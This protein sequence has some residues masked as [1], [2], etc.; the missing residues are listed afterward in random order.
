VHALNQLLAAVTAG[1]I[2]VASALLAAEPELLGR[3]DELGRTPLHVAAAEAQLTAACMLLDRGASVEPLA[4]GGLSPLA[5]VMGSALSEDDKTLLLELL[6]RKGALYDIPTAVISNDLEALGS[7]LAAHP[8]AVRPGGQYYAALHLA[9]QYGRVAAAELLLTAGADPSTPWRGLAGATPLHIAAFHG[10]AAL[11]ELL[12]R[13][14]ADRDALDSAYGATPQEWA[15]SA[16]HA[17]AV[18]LLSQGS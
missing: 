11:I 10:D 5:L 18:A 6:A 4:D 8:E 7:M 15:E 14:G 3:T 13:C 1:D 9:A 16:D 12:L 17:D 2:E